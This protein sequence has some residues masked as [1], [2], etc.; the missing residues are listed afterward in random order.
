[1]RILVT[2]GKGMV[3]RTIYDLVRN[4]QDNDYI[5]LSRQMCNLL[6]RQQVLNYFENNNFD[7]IIHLAAAVGGLFKNMN[8]NINMF[9]DN[10]KINENVLEACHKNRIKKRDI[11]FIFL[12]LSS[13]SK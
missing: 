7:Y 11:L 10:I 1:M 3:G 13:E 8:Q 6:N 5:F 2:G 9:S 4:D 12:Y